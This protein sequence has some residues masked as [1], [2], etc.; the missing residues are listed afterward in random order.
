MM[1]SNC[2]IWAVKQWYR[3]GGCLLIRRSNYGWWPHFMWM[4]VDGTIWEYAPDHKY[5][6]LIPPV[7]FKG[8]V[9]VV[10]IGGS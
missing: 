8:R 4:N 6:Q 9:R 10:R 1:R 5:R 2:L 7:L 3:N